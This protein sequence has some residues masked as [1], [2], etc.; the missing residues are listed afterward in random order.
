MIM[1]HSGLEEVISLGHVRNY[2]C[3]SEVSYVSVIFPSSI[4]VPSCYKFQLV[5]LSWFTVLCS[6]LDTS[7]SDS[8]KSP[9]CD[10]LNP[11]NIFVV[12]INVPCERLFTIVIA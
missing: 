11:F 10:E 1:N 4:S 6:S 5:V 9:V 2:T 8:I 12:L 3:L 7:V